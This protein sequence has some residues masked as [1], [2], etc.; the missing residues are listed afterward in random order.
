MTNYQLTVTTVVVLTLL[1]AEPMLELMAIGL[2]SW[3]NLRKR[4]MASRIL[5]SLKKDGLVK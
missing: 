5:A 4:Q 1:F 2:T 3:I